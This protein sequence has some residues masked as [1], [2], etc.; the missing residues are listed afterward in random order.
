MLIA[1]DFDH[2]LVNLDKPLPG[3]RE[4]MEILR[5]EGHKIMIFSCNNEDWIRKVLD[6]NEI[7]YDY[8]YEGT[9][10]NCGA[11][12]DDRAIGFTGDWDRAVADVARL[13]E[14]RDRIKLLAL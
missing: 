13:Q 12:I 5:R 7:P 4:A 14:R 8:I 1:V 2:T 3:A 11:Y 10:P 6:N 9:K